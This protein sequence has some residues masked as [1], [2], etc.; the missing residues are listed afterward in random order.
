MEYNVFQTIVVGGD[1]RMRILIAE[2]EVEIAKALQVVLEHNRYKVDTVHTGI[3]ALAYA[4]QQNYDLIVLDI[5]MPGLDGI[6]VLKSIRAKSLP[7]PVLMLTAKGELEDR[8]AGLSAGADD[9]LAKPF[10][11]AEFL[12]RV[13]ALLRRSNIYLPDILELA[14]TQLNCNTYELIT[15]KNMIRLNNKEFQLMELFL[16]NPRNVFSTEQLMERIWGYESESEINVVWTYISNLR[17][18]LSILESGL[19]IKTIRGAGFA[20]E[21]M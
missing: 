19:V 1:D 3:D 18:K 20:L 6:S 13:K 8:V 14:D 21:E 17:K 5:M 10:A 11:T 2:D 4:D 12:A 15:A 7:V 9:Y 16:R